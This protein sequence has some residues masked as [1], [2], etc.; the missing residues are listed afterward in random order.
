MR[1]PQLPSH[2]ASV[3]L[4][5]A[6]LLLALTLTVASGASAQIMPVQSAEEPEQAEGA[7]SDAGQPDTGAALPEAAALQ[8]LLETLE[9]PQQRARLLEDLRALQTLQE[10]QGATAQDAQSPPV[11]G[12]AGEPAQ[13]SDEGDDVAGTLAETASQQA[14]RVTGVLDRAIGA[15]V[16][17]ES[18]PDWF[19]E[20]VERPERRSFWLEIFTVGLGLPLLVALLSRW[21][22]GL[23]LRNTVRRLKDSQPKT[24]ASRIA[25]GG[26]RSLLEAFQVA[27][28]LGAGWAILL[29]VPRSDEA[30]SI[31][32]L[33]IE[34]IAVQ[35][36]VGV[37]VRA[38]LAPLAPALRPLPVSNETAAYLYVWIMRFS[39]VAVVGY[40]LAHI[41]IPLGASWAGAKAI[42]VLAATVLAGLMI[43]LIVQSRQLVAKAIRGQAPEGKRPSQV[44]R[45]LGDIWHVLAIVYVLMVYGIF[46][47]GQRDGFSFLLEGTGVTVVTPIVALL[48]TFLVGQALQILFKVDDDLN[49]RFP[50][51]KERSNLYRPLL[52]KSLTFLIWMVAAIVVAEGWDIDIYT[53]LDGE[54]RIAL[55]RSVGMILL[56][57]LICSLIWEFSASGIARALSGTTPDGEPR[58]ASGRAKTLLPLLRR[59]I[60]IVLVIF[61]G[62]VILSEIG[63][64][65]APLLASAG[66]VG[67]AIGFGSQ[68]L[69]RDLITGLFILIEDT[70]SVGDVV[71]VGDH[72]G[73]VEDLSL[74]TIR[75]RDISGSVHVVPFGEVTSVVNLT[76]DYAYALMDIGVGYRE[77][78]DRVS[79]V[80]VE[81][82]QDLQADSA[83]S[84]QILEPLEVLGVNELADSAVILRCRIKTRPMM[85][86][87]VKR[88]YYRR[89]KKR[90]DQEGIEIPFPHTTLYFGVDQEGKAPPG[91][92]LLE[93]EQAAKLQRETPTTS[94]N[95]DAPEPSRDAKPKTTSTVGDKG[96]EAEP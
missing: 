47:S 3:T 88:E 2:L 55:L 21:L 22:V 6:S 52:S 75:L 90:F 58:P 70:V 56:V 57:V 92:I 61:G 12:D 31:A 7:Q 41:A 44:R 10:R 68:A 91:R 27:A 86:W 81:V 78:T 23:A 18:L 93:A 28:V 4:L 77:D 38:L 95:K 74:R 84:Y 40:V 39:L 34:A 11:D 20:Q 42:E 96:N 36:G 82:G 5:V 35:T 25:V 16:Q 24:I 50:G 59:A 19:D 54:S 71:T 83:W 72:T 14:E 85:Q 94:E 89:M 29:L 76:R 46:V 63:V 48:L 65:I 26:L 73:V 9:D 17:V 66:V 37:V 8:R 33:I 64:D 32:E 43:V 51:L 62:M 45:R 69:V 1:L 87:A 15:I 79:E 13:A 30:A 80:I 53:A 49:R 60:L 67:I